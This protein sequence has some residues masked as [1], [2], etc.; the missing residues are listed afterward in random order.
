MILETSPLL[1]SSRSPCSRRATPQ[2]P[3]PEPN[4]NLTLSDPLGVSTRSDESV[5]AANSSF[6]DGVT[7][8][9]T[10][11]DPMTVR[12]F[13]PESALSPRS[14]RRHSHNNTPLNQNPPES[15]RNSYNENLEA[16]G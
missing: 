3:S 9:D 16:Y 15:R 4:L 12:I 11:I 6:T 1:D 8:K 10:H 7:T 13:L 5:A 14:D 2:T